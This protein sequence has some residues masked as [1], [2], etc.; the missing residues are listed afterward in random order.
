M[1]IRSS[2][3]AAL[4]VK[5]AVGGAIVALAAGAATATAATGS[6]NPVNWGQHI[7]QVVKGC[8]QQHA[9]VGECVSDVAQEH[10]EQVR[11][12]HSEA[13]EKATATPSPKPG[14]REGQE[15][16]PSTTHGA[17]AAS[18]GQGQGG[19]PANPG[20]AGNHGHDRPTPIP[21]SRG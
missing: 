6:A 18:H 7:V 9:Q 14:Q 13:A 20:A 19:P 1:A 4:G 10:G 3:M 5:A 15:S 11:A 12:Q 16:S 2:I 21:S 17:A 8:K